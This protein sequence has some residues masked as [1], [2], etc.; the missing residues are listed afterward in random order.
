MLRYG[1]IRGEGLGHVS[2]F[3]PAHKTLQ[4]IE[5][6]T[7]VVV[8]GWFFSE[9]GW[10]GPRRWYDTGS[11]SLYRAQRLYAEGVQATVTQATKLKRGWKTGGEL[12]PGEEVWIGRRRHFGWAAEVESLDG[13]K[14]GRARF[15]KRFEFA[16]PVKLA[17]ERSGSGV[18]I[19][20]S[21]GSASKP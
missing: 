8:E 4:G 15:R 11:R 19:A 13:S 17:S 5:A 20:G 6:G 1:S 7:R 3:G 2:T 21:L 12:Q 16:R 14:S 10:P 9:G 18:G